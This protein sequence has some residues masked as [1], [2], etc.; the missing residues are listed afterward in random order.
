MLCNEINGGT[1]FISSTA[2]IASGRTAASGFSARTNGARSGVSRNS[3]VGLSEREA[4]RMK[5]M[6]SDQVRKE[7]RENIVIKGVPLNTVDRVNTK[8]WAY[9]FIKNRIG[10]EAVIVYTKINGKVTVVTEKVR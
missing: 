8:K 7:R 10:I 6:V 9:D 3:S 1:G 2:S 5:K 4:M